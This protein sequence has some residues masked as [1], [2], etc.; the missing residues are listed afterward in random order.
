MFN[1]QDDRRNTRSTSHPQ[2]DVSTFVSYRAVVLALAQCA[3]S[4]CQWRHSVSW[5]PQCGTENYN[6]FSCQK[7]STSVY[8]S[9]SH[10]RHDVCKT[11]CDVK[12]CIWQFSS[13]CSLNYLVVHGISSYNL[14]SACHKA[15][16]FVPVCSA[17]LFIHLN[18]S[19]TKKRRQELF[20]PPKA[21]IRV[22]GCFC[23]VVKW[24]VKCILF[25]V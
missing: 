18:A 6:F 11:L 5:K 21:F 12:I 2:G 19:E 8:I 10:L 1:C 23:S 24:N 25:L 16:S 4:W 3:L 17:I 7:A 13:C 20:W 22:S 14:L 9:L 15:L